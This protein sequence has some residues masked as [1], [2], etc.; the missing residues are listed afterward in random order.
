MTQL[1]KPPIKGGLYLES[2][3][4]I[5][6]ILLDKTGTLTYGTPEVVDVHPATGISVA[7]LGA[8]TDVARESAN[9]VL[10]RQ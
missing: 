3:A 8:G 9:V 2:L 7:C 1:Q 10:N 4:N 5:D 6:T